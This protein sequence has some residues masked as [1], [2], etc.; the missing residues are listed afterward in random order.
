M[1]PILM[2]GYAL[3]FCAC[4]NNITEEEEEETEETGNG[5]G[6]SGDD[7]WVT[8]LETLYPSPGTLW[9]SH[10]IGAVENATIHEA[11]LLLVS[12]QE[13]QGV[14]SA[15]H[16]TSPSEAT[17]LASAY[18]EGELTDWSI[19]SKEEAKTLQ[20]AIGGDRLSA[21]NLTLKK[22]GAS[23]LIDNEKDAEGNNV[24]YL[25]ENGSYT[26]TWNAGTS[27]IS[28]AGSKRSYYLRLVKRVKVT[29]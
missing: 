25:C 11:E 20:S 26:F 16:A 21:T 7:G 6:N 13:W 3:T 28:K 14:V 27:K 18:Q 5:E 15:F 23:L 19:P 1:L 22:K 2:M 24:R 9:R 17:E 8:D 4:V 12:L 10:L 29:P